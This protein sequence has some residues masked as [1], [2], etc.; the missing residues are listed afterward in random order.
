MLSLSYTLDLRLWISRNQ[1]C[2]LVLSSLASSDETHEVVLDS[3]VSISRRSLATSTSSGSRPSD[4]QVRWTTAH[5]PPLPVA[6]DQ[7][8]KPQRYHPTPF[9][10]PLTL[11]LVIHVMRFGLDRFDLWVSSFISVLTS[12]GES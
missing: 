10:C 12:I 4:G 2:C 3:D 9:T 8:N 11:W 6:V 7:Q 1:L 5:L